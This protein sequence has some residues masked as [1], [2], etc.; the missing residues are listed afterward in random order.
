MLRALVVLIAVTWSAV[1]AAAD[2]LFDA[3]KS[4]DLPAIARLLASGAAVN[5]R[6][7][8]QATPLI[9]AALVGQGEAAK[10]LLAKGADIQARNAGGFT[11][12]HAAAYAGSVPVATLLLDKGAARDDAENKAGVTA[13]FVAAEEN[14][15]EFVEFM[16][17]RG[18]DVAKTEGHGYSALTRAFWKGHK[19]MM[20][21]LK[22][23]GL[24]CQADKLS[25][26][27][28]VQCLAIKS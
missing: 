11:A 18:S 10:L 8:D 24:A 15:P 1:I 23:H 3:A 7:R 2:P 22:R 26:S 6:D 19:D 25:A 20:R 16:I 14:H 13:F 5:S 9:A 17:S 4:G 28:L 27:E 21:L 12:L